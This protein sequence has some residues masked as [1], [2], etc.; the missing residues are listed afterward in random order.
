M[1]EDLLGYLLG[2]LEPDEM[3]RVEEWL[4]EDADA[5]RELMEL[6]R[7]LKRLEAADDAETEIAD[8]I[9]PAPPA[10][11]VS[12]TMASL[13]P[14]APCEG[15]ADPADSNSH[16]NV[17]SHA[18]GENLYSD[19]SLSSTHED[20]GGELWSLRDWAASI[21]AAIILVAIAMPTLL[22]GRFAAR[23]AACQNNLR[24]LG[25]AMTQF[26]G[27]N[28]QSRLPTVAPDGYQAFAGI[29]ALRLYEAGLLDNP[30]QTF[31]PSIGGP[32][33]LAL[34]SWTHEM[35]PPDFPTTRSDQ[36][37][38]VS[39]QT[40]DEIG[41][42]LKNAP[43]PSE[44]A[45]ETTQRMIRAIRNLRL[46]QMTAGGHYA[47]TLGIR[48]DGQFSSPRFEARTQFAVM[49]DAVP[50][51]VNVGNPRT[52]DHVAF[53][54]DVTSHGGRGIN[55]LYED[56]HVGFLPSESLDRVPDSPLMNNE[57]L[58]EA[59]VTL[60]DASLGPSWQAPF[61]DANQR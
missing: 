5:R 20:G 10:D 16:E 36:P 50:M 48:D 44:D 31:C 34:A 57:G 22:E 12:R 14:F 43:N 35:F 41:R 28:A 29:Y 4:R 39:L 15:D 3:R 2:A 49:S 1:Q 24:E 54:Y 60:D 51:R 17:L 53:R 52:P 47:Y 21:T 27:R 46:I 56:G 42:E 33:D 13:P 19:L 58:L 37:R 26:A 30:Q 32:R 61:M 7:V 38:L 40:L 45:S 23:K 6:E 55:V 9:D 18:S 59:G 11:L 25:V 8:G